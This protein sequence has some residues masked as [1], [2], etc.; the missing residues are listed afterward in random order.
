MTWSACAEERVVATFGLTGMVD[1]TAVFTIAKEAMDFPF[2]FTVEEEAMIF[3]PVLRSL[4]SGESPVG[5][6]GMNFLV[7][8]LRE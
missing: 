3:L 6:I 7:F 5:S 4:E 8:F 2:G 1:E